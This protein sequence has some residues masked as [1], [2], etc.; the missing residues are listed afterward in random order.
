MT[1]TATTTQKISER[2]SG[3]D[4]QMI[5]LALQRRVNVVSAGWFES[6]ALLDELLNTLSGDD[7]R[8]ALACEEF[9][10]VDY[11]VRT[12]EEVLHDDER[13][14]VCCDG[15]GW[16]GDQRERCVEHYEPLDSIWFS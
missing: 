16:T 12:R 4:P 5:M 2:V 10:M 1:T 11:L 15:T 8:E 13:T 14:R 3:R 9:A 7:L 6:S